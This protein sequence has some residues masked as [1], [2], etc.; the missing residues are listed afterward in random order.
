[1]IGE[2]QHREK[3]NSRDRLQL[4]RVNREQKL[5]GGDEVTRKQSW[6]LKEEERARYRN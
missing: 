1:M 6:I 2:E 3:S 4:W 5:P